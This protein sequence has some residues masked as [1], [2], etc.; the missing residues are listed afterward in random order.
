VLSQFGPSTWVAILLGGLLAVVAF[1]PVA[2]VRYRRTGRLR[3]LDVVVLG[4]VAV[5]SVALWSYTLIP[6]PESD[7]FRCVSANLR[8][9]QFVDDIR[10]DGHLL[11]HNRALLQVVFNVV[12]FLPL[13]FFLRVLLR[14]GAVVATTVGAA[15]SLAIE[16]T[17]KTGIWGLYHCA[18]RVFDV[19]DL[20]LNTIGAL[21][22][23]LLALPVA[24]LLLRRRPAPAVHS[25]TAGRRVVGML[26]DLAV[27]AALGVPLTIAWRAFALYV[28]Q[29]SVDDLPDWPDALLTYG[30]PALVEGY[31]VLA[32]GRTVGEA[33]VQLEP[34]AQPGKQTRSRILKFGFGV[35]GFLL[36]E[37]A[38][39]PGQFAG[40]VFAVVT[41]VVALRSRD[42]RGLSHVVADME[43]RIE[44][45]PATQ[46][47]G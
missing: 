47:T 3:P 44:G 30:A 40:T 25:V 34:V 1:V 24:S 29:W 41:L 33:A 27:I 5:Y 22:G 37:S 45:A 12:L 7:S 4:A 20:M 23:S 19:D 14:R 8:P 18:Y 46:G 36:L 9:F 17:Q 11:L 21:L 35:G 28:L 10:S 6:L 32:R 15:V 39:V 2:V 13:G 38:L 43:L 26:A 16:L 31:W 42:H